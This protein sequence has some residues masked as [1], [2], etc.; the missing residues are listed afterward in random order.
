MFCD[1]AA[2]CDF[3]ICGICRL[4]QICP[5]FVRLSSAR[6]L[7]YQLPCPISHTLAIGPPRTFE[8]PFSNISVPSSTLSFLPHPPS[9]MKILLSSLPMPVW[10]RLITQRYLVSCFSDFASSTNQYFWEQLTPVL[11]TPNSSARSTLK[12]ASEL[13]EN[14][15]VRCCDEN[16]CIIFDPNNISRSWWCWQGLVSSH[17]LRDARKLVVRWLFQGRF[18]PTPTLCS[19]YYRVSRRRRPSVTHGSSLP[20]CIDY[21]RTASMLP[22]SRETQRITLSQI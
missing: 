12:N 17:I 3:L 18:N 22:F 9:L 2:S 13:V 19:S 20:K 7:D 4:S 1:D 15:T 21:P 11:N 5:F 16:H 10:T 8:L 14:T 6:T